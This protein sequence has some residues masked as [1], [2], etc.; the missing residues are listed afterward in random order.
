VLLGVG[1]GATALVTSAP[2]LAATVVVWTL[3]EIVAAPVSAAYV[4]DVSPPHMRGR[5]AGAW[6]MTYGLALIVG[7][8]LGT[9]VYAASPGLLWAG[10]VAL[11]L[12]S[13]AL[14]LSPAARP[15]GYATTAS[16]STN[17]A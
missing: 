12:I 13:A 5:Y 9:A 6:G 11:G 2:A 16:R 3:G 8:A 4:A 14:V 15:K 10:C 17:A 1:F 7:P